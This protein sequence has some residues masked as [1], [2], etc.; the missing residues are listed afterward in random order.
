[1][2]FHGFRHFQEFRGIDLAHA[3]HIHG[4]PTYYQA[5]YQFLTQSSLGT[6]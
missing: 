6:S 2:I 3:S 1:M 4:C 5:F